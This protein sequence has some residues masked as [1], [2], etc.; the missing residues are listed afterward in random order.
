MKKGNRRGVSIE[1]V[2]SLWKTLKSTLEYAHLLEF[3]LHAGHSDVF[4]LLLFALKWPLGWM[5]V[6][7]FAAA[8]MYLRLRKSRKVSASEWRPVKTDCKPK[9]PKGRKQHKQKRKKSIH[10][11]H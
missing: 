3:I 8:Y 6:G 9:P 5:L 1:S 4:V 11:R 10:K 2:R 7:C